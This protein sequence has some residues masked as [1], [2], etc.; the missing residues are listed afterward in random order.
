MLTAPV[1]CG[2]GSKRTFGRAD[3][4]QRIF[5]SK[6]SLVETLPA[7][8]LQLSTTRTDTV[9]VA[10]RLSAAAKRELPTSVRQKTIHAPTRIH[11]RGLP[12]SRSGWLLHLLLTPIERAESVPAIHESQLASFLWFSAPYVQIMV[13]WPA[14]EKPMS[15]RPA[16]GRV[17]RQKSTSTRTVSV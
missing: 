7:S 1:D 16:D 3:G 14:G 12:R 9:T 6:V 4:L 8:I 2:A 15:S 13:G 5:R 17:A 11:R 10:L